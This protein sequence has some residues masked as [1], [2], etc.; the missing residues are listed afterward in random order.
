MR[1]ESPFGRRILFCCSSLLLTAVACATKETGNREAELAALERA[2][3]GVIGWAKTKDFDLLYSIIANDSA[4]LE[5]HPDGVAVKGFTEFKKLEEIWASPDFR[6][7]RH[8]IRDLRIKLSRS[9]DVAWFF[10][11]LDDINEWRGQPASWIDTRWTGVLEKR[12]G[13]WVMVQMHF[14][15]P[16]V[17]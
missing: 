14:S 10:C 16:A 7:I 13:R 17:G 8:E 12:D 3:D 4:Y 5:V 15:N 2:I 9:G 1:V 6:A 11:I